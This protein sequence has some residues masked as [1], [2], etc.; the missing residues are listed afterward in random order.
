MKVKLSDL[1][2]RWTAGSDPDP[3]VCAACGQPIRDK[4]EDSDEPTVPIR[5]FRVRGGQT[6]AIAL[7]LECYRARFTP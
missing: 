1:E 2:C 3:L 6:Q 7:H 4:D 5:L